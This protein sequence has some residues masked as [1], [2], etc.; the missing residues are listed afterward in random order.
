[1][2][3]LLP[4][5]QEFPVNLQSV[6]QG[7]SPSPR[8]VIVGSGFSGL[9]MGIRLKQAGIDTFTILEKAAALGG[10]WRDN[11]YPG[12]AC[13][14]QSHL[15]SFSFEPNPHWSRMFAEQREIKSYLEHCAEK[16]ELLP[17]LRYGVEV[18]STVFDEASSTWT[19]TLANGEQLTADIVVIATGGLSRPAYPDISGIRRFT[20]KIFHSARWDHAYDLT[21]KRVGVIGTGAS[22]IQFVPQIAPRVAQLALFQR[23]PPWILPK[24]DRAIPPGERRLYRLFPFLQWLYRILIYWLLETR[25]LGFVVSPKLMLLVQKVA[26]EYLVTSVPDPVLQQKLLPNYTFGCKRVLISN[27]Y[28]PAL[29]RPNVEVIDTGISEIEGDCVITRDGRRVELDALILG[30]GFKAS[31]DAAPFEVRGRGGVDLNEH[32]KDG[33]EAYLGTTVAGFPN[34]FIISGPNTGLGHTSL[35]LMIESQ[36]AHIMSAIKKLRKKG[37]RCIEVLREV[38][39]RYNE[40]LQARLQRS[41]WASGCSSWYQTRT[42]RNTTLWPHFTFVF[43]LLTRRARSA[44]FCFTAGASSAPQLLPPRTRPSVGRVNAPVS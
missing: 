38:E 15:Y 5:P 34:F 7:P 3:A 41:V 43:R 20:G 18:T 14:V 4:Q 17:H 2:T 11:D 29:L 19:V 31:E 6:A 39:Q 36:T 27:D 10:T 26:L 25:V 8:V 12:A 35:V 21:G 44:D 28:Y 16:Y 32:W 24:P 1:V 22:S 33:A 40:R 13:D 9:C 23:T 42:G 37:A 30:T